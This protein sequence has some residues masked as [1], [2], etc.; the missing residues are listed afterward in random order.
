MGVNLPV[1][2][3][4]M[5]KKMGCKKGAPD[6]M[7]FEP[8]KEY[9]GLFIELKS[10]TGNTKDIEQNR[11]QEELNKRGY[12]AIIMPRIDDFSKAFNWFRN[13]VEEYMST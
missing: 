10:P 12:L 6:L 5:R 7:I 4:V 8:N 3:A 13:I 11:W 1:R 2:Y 9:K